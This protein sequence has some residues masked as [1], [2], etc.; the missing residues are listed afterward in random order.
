MATDHIT[1]DDLEPTRWIGCPT[2]HRSKSICSVLFKH[3][4]VARDNSVAWEVAANVGRLASLNGRRIGSELRDDGR[5]RFATV[6][7][8]KGDA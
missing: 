6:A 1:D 4:G 8:A 7:E 5:R 3:F 2:P